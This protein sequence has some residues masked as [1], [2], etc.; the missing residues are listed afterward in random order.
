V[1]NSCEAIPNILT[2]VDWTLIDGNLISN[3]FN[4]DFEMLY[5]DVPVGF[6]FNSFIIFKCVNR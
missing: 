3:D 6:I 4:V 1:I 5:T 2:I